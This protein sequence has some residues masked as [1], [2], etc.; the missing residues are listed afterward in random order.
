M[1]WFFLQQK[2]KLLWMS[3]AMPIFFLGNFFVHSFV[4]LSGIPAIFSLEISSKIP[5][6]LASKKNHQLQFLWT[7][8]KQIYLR[9]NVGLSIKKYFGN[10]FRMPLENHLEIALEISSTFSL[11]LFLISSAILF[12]FFS[13]SFGKLSSIVFGKW[14]VNS[15]GNSSCNY[16]S[17]WNFF[18][19]FFKMLFWYLL[20]TFPKIFN[21]ISSLTPLITFSTISLGI[22]QSVLRGNF[23]GF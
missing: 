6:K 19:L 1:F 2:K 7:F 5:F 18:N 4:Q 20:L 3:F 9:F 10:L 22:P 17:F 21:K 13:N 16:F 8:L 11:R 14:F 15:F 23:F 12:W